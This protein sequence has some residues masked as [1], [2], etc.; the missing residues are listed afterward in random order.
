MLKTLQPLNCTA[1][2]ELVVGPTGFEALEAETVE[3]QSCSAGTVKLAKPL[4]Y[5][6]YGAQ[7]VPSLGSKQVRHTSDSLLDFALAQAAAQGQV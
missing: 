3:V 5:A 4:A 1:G 2:D 6:H 7:L